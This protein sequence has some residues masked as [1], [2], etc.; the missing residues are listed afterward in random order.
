[1]YISIQH[2]YMYVCTIHLPLIPLLSMTPRPSGQR[3]VGLGDYREALWQLRWNMGVLS[4]DQIK[5]GK[6]KIRTG[7]THSYP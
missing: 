5:H 1:M 2:I 6:G 4:L 7:K 3:P